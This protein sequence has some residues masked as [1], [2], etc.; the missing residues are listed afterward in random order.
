MKQSR[1]AS[2]KEVAAEL[3]RLAKEYQRRAADL[4]SGRMPD[5]GQD[6]HG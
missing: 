6:Q 5:I 2:S 4:D 1:L 3:R